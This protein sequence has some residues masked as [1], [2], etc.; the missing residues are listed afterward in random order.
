MMNFFQKL[1]IF[2][3]KW[4]FVLLE[5]AIISVVAYGY[6]YKALLDFNPLQLQQ[7]GEQNG[8][9]VGPLLAEISIT[10]YGEIPLWNPFMQTGFPQAGDLLGHFW[11]PFSTIPVLIWG[12]I[13][14]MKVAVFLAFITAGLGQ[15]YLGRVFGLRGIFRLWSSLT[16]MLSGGL[17]L[18]WRLGWYELLLGAVWFPWVFGSFW[19]ALHNKKRSSLVYCSLCVSMVLLSGGG[20]YPF[21][22]LGCAGII[23]LAAYLTSKGEIRKHMLP[24][25]IGIAALAAGIVAVMLLPLITGYRLTNRIAGPDLSQSGSQPILYALMNYLIATPDWLNA[26]IL[27]T[28][29]GW[30]WF[31]LG[32]LSIVGLFFLV[33]AFRYRRYRPALIA[34]TALSVF[35][36]LW[37]SNRYPPLKYL[38]NW[39]GFLYT[40]RF[41]Q[42]LLIFAGSSILILSGFSLQALYYKVRKSSKQFAI[43]LTAKNHGNSLFIRVTD[44]FSFLFLVCLAYFVSDVY[45]VNQGIAFGPH[46]LDLTSIKALTWLKQYDPS[47]YYTDLGGDLYFWSWAPAAYNLEMPIINDSNQVE[48]LA[49]STAQASENSPFIATPKYQFLQSNQTPSTGA[50][51]VTEI[52]GY[53]LWYYPE[54][55]PFAFIVP[56]GSIEPGTK[57]DLSKTIPMEV[58]YEGLNKINVVADF[59]SSAD[60]LVVLV[61]DFPGWKLSVDGKPAIL[62]PI[63]YYLGTQPLP[64][65]HTYSFVFDPPL[66]HVGLLI[67]L[68]SIYMAILLILSESASFLKSFQSLFYRKRKVVIL[69]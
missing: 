64:G 45:K 69:K 16:F 4:R 30:N 46:S 24:R 43:S 39:F 38:Y 8:N 3:V 15:W 28:A 21:Y 50:Q 42:R 49:S 32:P 20:Y 22:L 57:L 29:N 41:P 62:T 56:E 48:R 53:Q 23:L 68:Y 10:R 66:Y 17:A 7:T 55:L 2:W 65:K 67:S 13:N 34:M 33:I 1:Q 14:G 11:M 31:Y 59:S 25:A 12:G 44:I 18:L 27:G 58:S 19:T 9:A 5:W 52:D 40:L 35:L 63:N 36:L 54:A 61:S 51:L 6:S 60:K 47:L 37:M 26:N